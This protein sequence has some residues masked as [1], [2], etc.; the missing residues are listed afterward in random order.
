MRKKNIDLSDIKENDLDRTSTFTDLMSRKERKKI[1]KQHNETNLLE[2]KQAM[3]REEKN[4][5]RKNKKTEDDSVK[6]EQVM[7]RENKRK[8]K[9]EILEDIEQIMSR[10]EKNKQK[11]DEID[12]IEEMISEKKR[13]TEDLTKELEKAKKEYNQLTPDIEENIGKTQILELTRQMKFNF[14]ENKM[15]NNRKKKNGISILNI[16][17]EINLLCIGYYLY[18]LIFTSFQEE[19]ENYLITGSII[20]S[21]VLLFGISV[22]TRKKVSKFFNILNILLVIVFIAFNAYTLMN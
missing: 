4:K 7:T 5:E 10:E 20:I 22:V 6:V 21:L 1:K 16:I 18:L 3:S 8:E 17:G 12:D 11:K 14:E 9:K 2:D 13:S 15:D 19:K